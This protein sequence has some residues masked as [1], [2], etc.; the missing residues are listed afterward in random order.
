MLD[1]GPPPD[2]EAFAKAVRHRDTWLARN[3]DGAVPVRRA[4]D[5]TL[6]S[7]NWQL[8]SALDGDVWVIE[9]D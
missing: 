5:R 3:C 9:P 6:A 1:G 7:V 4:D 8:E 2:S